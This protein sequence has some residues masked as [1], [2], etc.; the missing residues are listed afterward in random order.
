MAHVLGQKP[1]KR[2]IRRLKPCHSGEAAF[3]GLMGMGTYYKGLCVDCQYPLK[4][5]QC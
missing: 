5:R 4:D 2:N 1:R 3:G